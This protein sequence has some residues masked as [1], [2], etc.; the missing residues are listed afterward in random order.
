MRIR[1]ALPAALLLVACG[2]PVQ[3]QP[4]VAPKSTPRASFASLAVVARGPVA[5]G[6]YARYAVHPTVEVVAGAPAR[7][8][9]GWGGGSYELARLRLQGGALPPPG[10]VRVEDF[11]NAVSGCA[12]RGDRVGVYVESAPSLTRPGYQLLRVCVAAPPPRSPWGMV[13]V[14]DGPSMRGAR[15]RLARDAVERMRADHP[16]LQ[17]LAG[18]T[19]PEALLGDASAVLI[20]DGVALGPEDGWPGVL[21]L[22]VGREGARLDRV[23][24]LAQRWRGAWGY[25]H[26]PRDLPRLLAPRPRE[27]LQVSSRVLFRPERV[28]RYRLLGYEGVGGELPVGRLLPGAPQTVLFEV[29]LVDGAGPWGTLLLEGE[30]GSTRTTLEPRLAARF[31]DASPEYRRAALA[32]ALAEKLRGGYWARAVEYAALVHQ[33]GDAELLWMIDRAGRL[34]G[35]GDAFAAEGSLETV[36]F[37]EIPVIRTDR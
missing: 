27:A 13:M 11:V 3:R 4:G 37:D 6:W 33:V 35:R 12:P 22:A 36:G 8:T 26:E 31:E 29:R 15:A 28:A 14:D 32:A 9:L 21:V 2:A 1:R 34:D 19:A 18:R 10:A 7:F 20:T 5:P 17:A 16:E 24:E 25:L 30:D 23:A